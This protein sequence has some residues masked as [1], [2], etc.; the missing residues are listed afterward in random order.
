MSQNKVTFG[1]RDVH[2]AFFDDQAAVHLG[3]SPLE[4][5]GAFQIQSRFRTDM[6]HFV[7][8]LVP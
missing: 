8:I 6:F 3:F 1:L 4:D 2:I 5:Q 7:S